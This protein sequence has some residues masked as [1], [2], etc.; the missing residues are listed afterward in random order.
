MNG[1]NLQAMTTLV[2]HDELLLGKVT[3]R[4]LL[5]FAQGAHVLVRV[6]HAAAATAA[7]HLDLFRSQ[8]TGLYQAICTVIYYTAIFYTMVRLFAASPSLFMSTHGDGTSRDSNWH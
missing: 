1:G 7:K 3:R 8:Q 4:V 6:L 5:A 2:V